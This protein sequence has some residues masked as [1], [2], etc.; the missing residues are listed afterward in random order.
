MIS[1]PERRQRLI[2]MKP[3]LYQSSG[4][5]LPKAGR[6][7]HVSNLGNGGLFMASLGN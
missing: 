5:G 4:I 3:R 6:P 1:L 2:S 7:A